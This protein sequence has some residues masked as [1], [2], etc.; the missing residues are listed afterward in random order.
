MKKRNKKTQKVKYK[1]TSS[2]SDIYSLDS[3]TFTQII[4]FFCI[5][6]HVVCIHV[7][8]GQDLEQK[9]MNY[10]LLAFIIGTKYWTQ[11]V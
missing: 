4:I 7:F 6:I 5:V 2:D 9:R 10:L 8:L 11:D 3:T 1:C